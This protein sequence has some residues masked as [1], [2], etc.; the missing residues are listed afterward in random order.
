MEG[1]VVEDERLTEMDVRTVG[2]DEVGD[3][4]V[5]AW[6]PNEW[7]YVEVASRQVVDAEIGCEVVAECVD[8]IERVVAMVG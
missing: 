1:G 8:E 6:E 7:R 2:I 5:A 3:E 4:V